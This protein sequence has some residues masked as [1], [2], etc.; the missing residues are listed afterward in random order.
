VLLLTRSTLRYEAKRTQL[1][2]MSRT[3]KLNP[4]VVVDAA[5]SVIDQLGLDGLT[6][7][8]VATAAGAPPMSLYT[9]F[10]SK[11]ELLDAMARE[12]SRRLYG[13]G[14]GATWQA[15]LRTSCHHMRELLV[16]HPN[17]GVLIARPAPAP[18]LPAR[19]RLIEQMCAA[20]FAPGQALTHITHAGL[21][22]LGFTML[23]LQHRDARGASTI[24]RRFDTLRA[25]A[26]NT[27]FAAHS[28]LTQAALRSIA[29]LDMY[30]SFVAVLDAFIAGIPAP[31]AL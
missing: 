16:T 30:A 25:D 26:A 2:L 19:E 13:V 6:I 12:L 7:R 28:P 9:H 4:E 5:L 3:S 24:A 17:W 22:T 21:L 23:E 29:P 1:T 10:A 18:N 20:G 11:D 8:A 31:A 14:E 27:A 15:S